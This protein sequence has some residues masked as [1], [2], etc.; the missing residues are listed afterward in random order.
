M[1]LQLMKNSRARWRY[2]WT[3]LLFSPLSGISLTGC[4]NTCFVFVSNPPTGTI[5]V[6]AGNP[7]PACMLTKANGTVRV[8]ARTVPT[9]ESCPAS[10][11]IAHLFVRVLGIEVNPSAMADDA[12]PDWQEVMQ[13][14]PD[15]LARFELITEGNRDPL[16]L[17]EAATIPADVYRVVRLRFAPD[18][19]RADDFG[20]EEPRCGGTAFNCI[21]LEDG[22]SYPLQF[23]DGRPVL[24]I[25]S[26]NLAGGFLLVPPDS[27][28]NLVIEINIAWVLSPTVGKRGELLPV[29]SGTAS[30]E[31]EAPERVEE[32][33]R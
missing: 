13:R 24:R 17:G 16:P 15:Q 33:I 32:R 18:Q 5:N 27:N 26:A 23:P 19:R 10:S 31:R 25:G 1:A 14:G 20:S 30:V 21:V 22:R 9:C 3:L 11:R 28:S 7:R 12:S 4:N 2:V 29:L 8:V 6:K